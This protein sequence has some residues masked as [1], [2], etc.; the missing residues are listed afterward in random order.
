M[1]IKLIYSVTLIFIFFLFSCG[2]KEK[3]ET[4]IIKPMKFAS[5]VQEGGT[6]VKT[7]N[8]TSQSGAETRLSFRT[9]GLIVKLN[10]KIGDKVK[11]GNL[12][13]QL[14]LNDLQLN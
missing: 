13:A 12:L 6:I 1:K 3:Q 10:A 8:G 4:K 9:N 14:D 5:V 2:G 11:K 7:F